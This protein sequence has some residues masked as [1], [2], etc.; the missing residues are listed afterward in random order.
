MALVI[1]LQNSAHTLVCYKKGEKKNKEEG[2]L[3][4]PK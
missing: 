2:K 4:Y 3:N 1:S